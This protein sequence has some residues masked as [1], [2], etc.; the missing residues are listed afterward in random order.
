MLLVQSQRLVK[1]LE[2]LEIKGRVEA[3]QTAELLKSARILR[4][5]LETWGDLQSINSSE[6]LSANAEGK[7]TLK[8]L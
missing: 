4:R 7:K 6:R 5:V 1:G 8:E 2:D 3:I